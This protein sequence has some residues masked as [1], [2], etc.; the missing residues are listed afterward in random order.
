MSDE[1]KIPT[2]AEAFASAMGN[3][4]DESAADAVA[5]PEAAATA[6]AAQEAKGDQQAASPEAVAQAGTQEAPEPGEEAKTQA[7]AVQIEGEGEAPRPNEQAAPQSAPRYVN[8]LPEELAWRGAD[9]SEKRVP[10]A[11]IEA[12]I[13]R[14]PMFQQLAEIMT[15]TPVDALKSALQ[16][17][18]NPDP[19]D[20]VRKFA[21]LRGYSPETHGPAPVPKTKEE[22]IAEAWKAGFELVNKDLEA[23]AEPITSLN[24]SRLSEMARRAIKREAAD[25]LAEADAACERYQSENSSRQETAAKKAQEDYNHYVDDTRKIVSRMD[26]TA[27]SAGPGETTPQ[28][29]ILAMAVAFRKPGQSIEDA[30]KSAYDRFSKW[31]INAKTKS[32]IA[33]ANRSRAVL[34]GNDQGMKTHKAPPKIGSKNESEFLSS[35]LNGESPMTV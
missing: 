31:S 25:Y 30:C 26:L 1:A 27:I 10:R 20:A 24:D 8:D 5:Q 7:A 12:V 16:M 32:V 3:E 9:G 22:L 34:A 33:Q 4:T 35:I 6:D 13:A 29:A 18:R 17:L 14:Q 11:Y 21:E 15:E 28:D 19:G 23:E 2:L